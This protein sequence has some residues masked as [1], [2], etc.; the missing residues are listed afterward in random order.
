MKRFLLI[1]VLLATALSVDAQLKFGVKGGLNVSKIRVSEGEVP[2]SKAGF[3]AGVMLDIA[4]T[5]RIYFNPQLLYTQRGFS[6]EGLEIEGL[7]GSK[8]VEAKVTLNYL[9]LPLDL[10]YRLGITDIITVDGIVG[11]YLAMG[12]SSKTTAEFDGHEI[13]SSENY[14][15][16]DDGYKRFDC[17]LRL[18]VG[19][20]LGS[21]ITASV[22]YDLGM[23]N[24]LKETYD[25]EKAKNGIFQVS[26]G[27]LF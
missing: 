21:H 14:F 13:T 27:W 3:H 10:N 5:K 19:A 22:V 1:C 16:A 11:P 12:L 4:L 15:S 25:D 7:S 6:L 26:V 8:G 23:T 24:L 2:D 17:G 9:Q 18:G 20:H